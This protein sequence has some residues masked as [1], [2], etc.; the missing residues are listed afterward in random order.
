MAFEKQFR[1][2]APLPRPSICPSFPPSPSL[3]SYCLFFIQPFIR[4]DSSLAADKCEMNTVSVLSIHCSSSSL[5][6]SVLLYIS[7]LSVVPTFP[8]FF[9]FP[10]IFSSCFRSSFFFYFS[11]PSLPSSTGGGG[12]VIPSLFLQESTLLNMFHLQ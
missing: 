2:P 12:G 3:L 7:N 1:C 4:I 10:L 11:L 8:L 9:P 6:L 5:H